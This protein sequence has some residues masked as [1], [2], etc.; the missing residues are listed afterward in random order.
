MQLPP[1]IEQ[2]KTLLGGVFG[3]IVLGGLGFWLISI[4]KSDTVTATTQVNP[5][6]TLLGPNAIL[7]IQAVTKDKISLKDTSFMDTYLI[8]H[9][10]DF[11][12]KVS[13]STSRGR[14]DPFSPYDSS[15]SSR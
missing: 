9:S 11:T 5:N 14:M 6:K 2:H 3:A 15:R 12:Q 1:I 7:F 8:K 13:T 10:E 4:L